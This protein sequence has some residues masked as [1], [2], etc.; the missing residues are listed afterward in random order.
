MRSRGYSLPFVIMILILISVSLATLLFVLGAGAKSTESMLGRRRLFYACDGASRIAAISAQNY[1][2][3]TDAPTATALRDFVCAEGGGCTEPLLPTFMTQTPGFSVSKFEV[4]RIGERRI[5]PIDS[6]PF[7]GMIALQDNLDLTVAAKKNDVGWQCE[8][9]QELTLG[10]IAMFQFFVF[11]DQPY[12]DWLPGPEMIAQGRVHANGDLCVF[13]DPGPLYLERATASGSIFPTGNAGCRSGSVQ[14]G[15]PA[16][17]RVAIVS[18][19][20]FDPLGAT[21]AQGSGAGSAHFRSFSTRPAS[22]A[23]WSNEAKVA[24]DSHLLDAAHSVS[25]LRLPVFGAA[26]E[27]VGVNA[28]SGNAVANQQNENT[29]RLLVDPLWLDKPDPGAAQKFAFKADIRIINGIWFLRN[30]DSPNEPGTPIWSDH[31]GTYETVA[32]GDAQ[33][34]GIQ[35]GQT[36]LFPTGTIPSLYSMYTFNGAGAYTRPSGVPNGVI[37]YGT[38]VRDSSTNP[39]IWASG[40]RCGSTNVVVPLGGTNCSGS[41]AA[42]T[43]AATRSGF[44]NS[45]AQAYF[46]TL[47]SGAEPAANHRA[48]TLPMNVDIAAL[49]RALA[50]CGGGELGS[51]FPGTC[52]NNNERR[53]NGVIYITSTWPG[54]EAETPTVPPAHGSNN[55]ASQPGVGFGGEQTA[56]PYPLCSGSFNE[57]NTIVG[58]FKHTPCNRYTDDTG[59]LRNARPTSVRIFNARSF[60]TEH[61]SG[62]PAIGG[63]AIAKGVF[64]NGIGQ[65]GL[66]VATNLPLYV[67]GDT[68]LTSFAD[69]TDPDDHWRPFLVAGDTVVFLSNAWND[70]N[71]RWGDN[72]PLTS[73]IAADSAYNVE[74]LAGWVPTTSSRFSGG[75]HN[76]PKQIENWS[77]RNLTL[78]GS[79]VIGWSS[80]YA[81][82]RH[83]G[84]GA[85]LAPSRDWAFDKHLESILNQ[86]PGAPLYDVQSTRRWKR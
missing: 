67:L 76:F 4:P 62:R 70:S 1:F 80:V 27:Q 38:L 45:M 65:D 36:T 71:A 29:S 83:G 55:D 15:N 12:T 54:S 73:R 81:R 61:P 30:P 23:T 33:P 68:N 25:A 56:L 20:S 63:D 44:R 74:V 7:E 46:N 22:L 10:K 78:R 6:G 11:S 60:N 43:L 82:W 66:T 59:N 51:H 17:A 31:P 2:G 85:F 28:G 69:S 32:D 3:Q 77:G 8:V 47:T 9:T 58:D 86:P 35:V 34:A 42:A 24:F 48:S 40:V 39:P 75:V 53:F 50:N 26:G 49:H 5:A 19:P 37:S 79:M 16:A 21:V 13:G 41:A 18:S 57:T 14:N 64:T 84:T 72:T 52:S